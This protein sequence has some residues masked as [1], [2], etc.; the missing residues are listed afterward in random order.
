MFVSV[1]PLRV[2]KTSNSIPNSHEVQLEKLSKLRTRFLRLL[3]KT[4]SNSCRPSVAYLSKL[5]DLHLLV[6][7][8]YFFYKK[9]KKKYAMSSKLPKWNLLNHLKKSN[10]LY[11]VKCLNRFLR[12]TFRG[13][14][15]S[16]LLEIYVLRDIIAHGWV[17]DGK[18]SHFWGA[19]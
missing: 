6:C 1:Q 5:D 14:R 2:L 16:F 10:I 3:G 17:E 18:Y 4:Q 12:V 11:Y 13:I 9:L 7:F 15:I 8:I 19:V